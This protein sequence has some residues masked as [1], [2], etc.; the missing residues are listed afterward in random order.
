MCKPMGTTTAFNM[1][2]CAK[3]I[4][5]VRNPV[6]NAWIQTCQNIWKSRSPVLIFM[7]QIWTAIYF[8]KI[9]N[10]FQLH[11]S[12]FFDRGY[13]E[14][15]FRKYVFLAIKIRNPEIWWSSIPRAKLKLHAEAFRKPVW[16]LNHLSAAMYWWPNQHTKNRER[17]RDSRSKTRRMDYSLSLF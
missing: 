1:N 12:R 17:G 15:K 14:S 4:K 9:L 3:L 6:W 8:R 16:S 11:L 13:C 2:E 7:M 5:T 10:A